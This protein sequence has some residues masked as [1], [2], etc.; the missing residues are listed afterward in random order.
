MTWKE[1][2]LIKFVNDTKLGGVLDTLIHQMV[3]LPCGVTS[4]AREMDQ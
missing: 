1:C 4:E 2:I 3:V